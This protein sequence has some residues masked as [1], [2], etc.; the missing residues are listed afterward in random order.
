M[1]TIIVA[2]TIL[3]LCMGVASAKTQ[4]EYPT[5]EFQ[6]P[7]RANVTYGY[8]DMSDVTGF[9]TVD[10]TATAVPHFHVDTYMAYDV[11]HWWCGVL[12]PD[13][14]SGDGYGNGWNDLLIVPTTDVTGAAYPILTF[15]HYYDSEPDFDFTY[16]ELM[17]GGVYVAQNAGYNGLIPGGTWVDLG[18]YGYIL[19]DA[20][21]TI[22]A[23]FHFISD[24]AWSDEDGDYDS[25]GGAYMVD[26]IKIFDFYGGF[27]YFLDD[28]ESGGL[29]TPAVPASAGDYW[30]LV[31]DICSSVVIPSW[32]CGDDADTSLIPPNLSNSVTT[33]GVDISYALTCTIRF[34]IHAEVPTIDNDYWVNSVVVDGATYGLSAWWGDFGQCGGFGSAGLGAGEN[35]TSLLPGASEMKFKITFNTTDNGC[36][37]GAAGGAGINLDDTWFEGE[38]V[39][40]VEQSSWGNIKAM[41]R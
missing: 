3:V 27:V 9:V 37:P 24:G 28:V 22:D 25:A 5:D 2:L 30:H 21:P 13:F 10:E 29:C 1:R 18:D 26:N 17:I 35:V 7:N 11:N 15:V 12:D 4:T 20:A 41:Y 39:V 33:A 19:E 38:P 36:G 8:F 34:A 40:A 23:R 6:G 16:V 14:A 31:D 32:W